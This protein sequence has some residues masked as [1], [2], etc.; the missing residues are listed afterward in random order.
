MS[1]QDA[2]ATANEEIEKSIKDYVTAWVV[3][4]QKLAA[5]LSHHALD[6]VE[7]ATSLVNEAC[8]LEYQLSGD[9]EICAAFADS[10]GIE[11]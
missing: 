2:L 6:Q 3:I 1:G 5:T 7:A 8:D 11:T 4:K 10:L 9:C